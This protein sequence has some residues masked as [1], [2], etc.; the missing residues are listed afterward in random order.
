M[1]EI[2]LKKY[3]LNHLN[4]F[5]FSC[6]NDYSMFLLIIKKKIEGYDSDM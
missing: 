6:Q 4:W 1:K 5:K 3:I 2:K